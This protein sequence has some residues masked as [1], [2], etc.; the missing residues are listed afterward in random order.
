MNRPD[1]QSMPKRSVRRF[2][3]PIPKEIVDTSPDDTDT[4]PEDVE[5]VSPP[6]AL[7]GKAASE[8]RALQLVFTEHYQS[9]S[10][11]AVPGI[12]HAFDVTPFTEMGKGAY[13]DGE[14]GCLLNRIARHWTGEIIDSRDK[15]YFR[16][17]IEP[18][19]GSVVPGGGVAPYQGLITT[20]SESCAV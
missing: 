18:R 2:S 17:L 9:I 7:V 5:E 3:D 1:F 16:L 15:G 12:V 11:A 20:G 4:P 13:S 10:V 8:A 6:L 19:K 14:M